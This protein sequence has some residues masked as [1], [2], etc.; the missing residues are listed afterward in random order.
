MYDISNAMRTTLELNHVLYIILTS[1]TA[2]TGLGFNRAVLFLVNNKERVLE[3]KMVIGPESGE[4][5]AKIWRYIE[6]EN[7]DLDDL[8]SAYKIAEN[9]EPLLSKQ[10]KQLKIPLNTDGGLLASAYTKGT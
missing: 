10:I 4:E 8:I 9:T 5:A 3:G 7:H 6:Q 2:H 1:V